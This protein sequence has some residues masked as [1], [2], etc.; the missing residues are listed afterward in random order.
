MRT[1]H[2]FLLFI[3]LLLTVSRVIGWA[4]PKPSPAEE[5]RLL[6]EELVLAKTP[7][8]YFL[9]FLK[10]K[11]I[12]LKS[13]GIILQEWKIESLHHWGDILPLGALTIEKKSTLFPPK[14]TKIEPGPEPE[15]TS[16][17]FELDALELKDMPSSFVIFLEQGIRLYVR[18]KPEK[19]IPRIG[20]I[21]HF[22][23]WYVWVPVRNLGCRIKKKPYS[24]IDIKLSKKE[25]AQSLYWTLADGLKGLIYPL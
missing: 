9:I 1:R 14:R 22:F 25:D 20:S 15:N 21:G 19:F 18:P 8:L 10:S 23:A 11:T 2:S 5:N 4:Q 3:L 7:S 16:T 24:A 13:R 12:A 6:K 17:T